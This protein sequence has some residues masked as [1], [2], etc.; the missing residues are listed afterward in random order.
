MQGFRMYVRSIFLVFVILFAFSV[1]VAHAEETELLVAP[2]I[3]EKANELAKRADNTGLMRVGKIA[4]CLVGAGFLG[5]AIAAAVNVN[6]K[7]Y[8]RGSQKKP[9]HFPKRSK[10]LVHTFSSPRSVVKRRAEMRGRL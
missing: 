8:R 1:H 6:T 3:T 10:T 9:T 4:W 2:E 5:S 7:S